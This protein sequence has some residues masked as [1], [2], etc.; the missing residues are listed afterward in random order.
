MDD[1]KK[2]FREKILLKRKNFDEYKYHDKNEGII[3][4][5][6]LL[7]D[8][9]YK[10]FAPKKQNILL[11]K[12]NIESVNT[13]YALGLYLPV[14]G[15]PD[16]NKLMLFYHF[17]IA[18]P[19]I[20]GEVIK[21]VYYQPGATLEKSNKQIYQ[22]TSDVEI[23]P[24]IIVAPAIAYDINGYRLGFG[25]GH[26]DKYLYDKN[27]NNITKIG[28]CFDEYLLE[29]LPRE[30]HDVRFDYIITDKMVLKL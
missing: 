30:K 17:G 23:I 1:L 29:Y 10:N 14:R 28:V 19:K 21:F 6:K 4:K 9:L 27:H 2:I 25:R 26:Y 7:L 16:L 22:P 18:L 15:E 8:S 24:K 11:A 12:H 5:V 3:V 13:D 20:A